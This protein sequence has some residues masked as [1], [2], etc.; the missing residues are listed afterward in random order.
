VGVQFDSAY[1]HY[2]DKDGKSI[3]NVNKVAGAAA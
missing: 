2:F 1:L 3:V